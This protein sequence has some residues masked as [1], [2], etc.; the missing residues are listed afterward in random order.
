MRAEPLLSLVGFGVAFGERT[1]LSDLRL[2]LPRFGMT[3]LVG[4]GGSGKSTLLRTL[5]GLNDAN[6]A[7]AIHGSARFAGAALEIPRRQPSF[8]PQPGIGMVLQH[9]R[10]FLDT[11][12]ENL[13]SALPNRSALDVAAQNS[14]IAAVLEENGAGA[15]LARLEDDA[16]ALTKAQQR[17]LAIL[18]VL[19]TEPLVVFA[20]EP[21]AGL[22]DDD[23]RDIVRM[24]RDQAGRRSILFV[25]HHQGFAIEA[26]GTTVL[27]AGGR[28][29]EIAPS[30]VFFSAPQTESGVSF[31]RTGGCSVPSPSAKAEDLE[32]APQHAPAP[33]LAPR[34][35]RSGY[36]GPRGFFWVLP[37]QL[38]GL[39]RPGLIAVLERD[40][41]GL[42]RLAVTTL[43]TLEE[44]ETVDRAALDRH[45][46]ASIH[47]PIPDM[48]APAPD[49]A[50]QLCRS[51]A[52]R[53]A[54]GGVVA[55]HC[56]AGLG[57]TGT[58]LA[59]QLVFDG[60]TARGAI[61]QVRH[62]NP[63]SIQSAAQTQFLASFE[64]FLRERGISRR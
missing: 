19:I 64:A 12:R 3:T 59:A 8:S 39:P 57:R 30:R 7:L 60:A 51:V 18:R 26:D 22:A 5:A 35:P 6:P 10:F 4:P 14:R 13:V 31:V 49:A 53:L 28:I 40:L 43:V 21:T 25:T 52:A 15:L 16:T 23:G 47:F 2:D 44:T 17:Q 63:Q 55:M 56:R 20:D 50:L 42:Q 27:L 11:V 24:L 61:E 32:S 54:E 33:S 34:V 9:A 58:M 41:E 62:L 37:D 48:D 29:Q 38:G 45:G 36:G 1:V 46:I